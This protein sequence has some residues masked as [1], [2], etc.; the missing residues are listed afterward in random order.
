MYINYELKNLDI[1]EN[2]IQTSVLVNVDNCQAS[3]FEIEKWKNGEFMLYVQYITIKA[4]IMQEVNIE[5]EFSVL[6]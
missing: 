6:I 5:E 1:N 4:E 3:E 2:I